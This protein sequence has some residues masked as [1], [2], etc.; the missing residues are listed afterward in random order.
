MY[1]LFAKCY[2]VNLRNITL[3]SLLI[4][5]SG[6]DQVFERNIEN[7]K[8]VLEFPADGTVTSDSAQTFYWRP[9][10]G[11]LRYEIQ[12]VSPRFDS[13]P[14]LIADTIAE[15]N[16]VLLHLSRNIYQWRVRA[17]NNSSTSDYSDTF[18]LR[19]Q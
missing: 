19:I 7:E 1:Y 18:T 17:F 4:I 14:R 6:C 13:F 16:Q 8:P 9:L 10:T 11:A 12:I 15:H 3:G 2:I 5:L